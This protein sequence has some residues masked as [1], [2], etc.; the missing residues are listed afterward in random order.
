MGEELAQL[1]GKRLSVFVDEKTVLAVGDA[2][3]GAAVT[4]NDRSGVR[5]GGFANDEAVGVEGRREEKEVCASVPCAELIPV[6]D[7]T[8]K[9]HAA[10]QAE[11]CAVLHDFIYITAAADKDHS[12]IRV[13]SGEFSESVEDDFETFVPHE[14][15]DEE[16]ARNI[17]RKIE[18]CSHFADEFCR[19]LLVRQ[20]DAVRHHDVIA[21]VAK[22][23]EIFAGAFA[24]GPDLIACIHVADDCLDRTLLQDLAVDRIRDIDVVLGVPGEDQREIHRFRQ[25]FCHD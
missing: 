14:A 17:L 11:R 7:R 9:N 22:R 21:F 24:D 19:N 1:R 2:F 6:G 10:V 4:D 5:S 15:A 25:S 16:E 20:I 23:T 18:T 12:E 13:L 8:C 3:G